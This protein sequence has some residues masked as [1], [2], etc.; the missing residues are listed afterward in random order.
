MRID[1]VAVPVRQAWIGGPPSWIGAPGW[2]GAAA[3]QERISSHLESHEV[4]LSDGVGGFLQAPQC[5]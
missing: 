2:V 4:R 5:S 1:G 3:I